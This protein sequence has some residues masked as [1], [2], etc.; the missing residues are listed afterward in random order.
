MGGSYGVRFGRCGVNHSCVLAFRK[1]RD[2]EQKSALLLACID[3][4]DLED[5][6]DSEQVSLYKTSFDIQL[7]LA[8]TFHFTVERMH[9]IFPHFEL[10]QGRLGAIWRCEAVLM[11]F[12]QL[13]VQFG[14]LHSEK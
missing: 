11:A 5:V 6:S 9:K 14:D 10:G 2:G 7:S 8:I 13:C 3:N 4:A 1:K 12:L